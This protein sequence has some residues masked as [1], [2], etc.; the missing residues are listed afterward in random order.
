MTIVIERRQLLG[1]AAGDRAMRD[2]H[3]PGGDLARPQ[4]HRHFRLRHRPIVEQ[5]HRIDPV[6]VD[7]RASRPAV[8]FIPLQGN[9]KEELVAR[10]RPDRAEPRIAGHVAR[11]A[12]LDPNATDRLLLAPPGLSLGGLRQGPVIVLR[13]H[14]S[15]GLRV[16]GLP[17]RAAHVLH[18]E[19]LAFER[20]EGG[21]IVGNVVLDLLRAKDGQAAVVQTTGQPRAAVHARP[22]HEL[23]DDDAV[24][25]FRPGHLRPV[26]PRLNHPPEPVLLAVP[27]LKGAHVAREAKPRRRDLL[28]VPPARRFERLFRFGVEPHGVRD[29][30]A[31]SDLIGNLIVAARVI[32]RRDRHAVLWKED[33]I[34][35]ADIAREERER[36]SFRADGRQ[37]RTSAQS[38]LHAGKVDLEPRQ[39][40]ADREL[41]VTNFALAG[42]DPHPAN[43]SVRQLQPPLSRTIAPHQRDRRPISP[44]LL[45]R[46]RVHLLLQVLYSCI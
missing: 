40:A 21:Q 30:A 8:E 1:A 5:R 9:G 13:E 41:S 37:G 46:I 36:I 33:R 43:R 34:G 18:R 19:R 3:V 23:E 4:Q 16:G 39:S 38:Q 20:G 44:D 15:A 7:Q 26:I 45:C 42:D 11:V 29:S 2:Q 14:V 32:R 35:P 10:D 17:L 27:H 28:P 22:D 12:R 25:Q 31:G 24:V 6:V